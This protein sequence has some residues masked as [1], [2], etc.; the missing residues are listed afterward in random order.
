MYVDD[1]LEQLNLKATKITD[2]ALEHLRGLA[3]L[4]TLNLTGTK[5]TDKR[6]RH[7]A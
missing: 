6:V 7:L 4:Q 5:T 1:N 2:A 3:N